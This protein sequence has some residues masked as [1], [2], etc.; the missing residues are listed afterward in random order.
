MLGGRNGFVVNLAYLRPVNGFFE[1]Q[2]IGDGTQATVRL[3]WCASDPLVVES[4]LLLEQLLTPYIK[5]KAKL[6]AALSPSLSIPLP[7][8][9]VLLW[10]LSGP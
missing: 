4:R 2:S 5:K 10:G 7:T 1:P 6:V 8:T 9:K 3:S